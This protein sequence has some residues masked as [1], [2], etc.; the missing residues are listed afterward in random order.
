MSKI[1]TG[2]AATRNVPMTFARGRNGDIYGVN[3]YERGIRWDNITGTAEQLG[4]SAPANKPTLAVGS[5]SSKFYLS[6]IDVV[7]GGY[8]YTTE[9]RVRISGGVGVS[10]TGAS[11]TDV[12]TCNNHGFTDGDPVQFTALTGGAGLT[13]GRTYYAIATS[14]NTFQV[15]LTPGGVAVN[16]SSDIS[17]GTVSVSPGLGG[18]TGTQAKA[19]AKLIDGRIHRIVIQE[20]GT[21][22]DH[23]PLISVGKPDQTNSDGTGCVLTVEVSGRV[24][25]IQIDDLGSGYTDPVVCTLDPPPTGGELAVCRM[26]PSNGECG[27]VYPVNRGEGYTAPPDVTLSGGAEA[28][29]VMDYEVIAV[30]VTNGGSGYRGHPRVVFSGGNG[31]GAVAEPVVGPDGSIASV[32]VIHGGSYRSPP[33]ASLIPDWGA[34]PKMAVLKP[35]VTSSLKG[36]YWAAIRY[37]DD[38]AESEGGPIPSSI[39]E[40]ADIELDIN[41]PS[42]SWSWSNTGMES[43]VNQIELWRTTADQGLVLYRVAVLAKNSTSYT[44][45]FSDAELINTERANYGAM[46]ITL[47]NGQ[48]NAR[49][50]TPPP[51]NKQVI[52]MFQDRAWYG[53]DVPGRKYDGSSDSEAAEPNALYFSEADEP[54]AVPEVNQLIIQ[55][56]V[57]GQDMITA[58]MPFGGGM[59]VYQERHCYRLSYVAQP[60]I[61]ANITLI[62]QRG[63]LNQRCWDVYDNVAYVVDSAGM[64]MLDGASAVPISDA[65]DNYWTDDIIHFASSKWFFVRVDPTTRVVRFFHSVS[66]GY[67]DRALCFH[68]ITK[69]WWVE[70]YAQTFAGAECLTTGGRQRVIAGGQSGS[71]YLFDSGSQDINSAGSSAAIA[72]Q[73]RTGNMPMSLTENSR[74]VRVLYKPTTADCTLSLALHYNG[75]STARPAAVRTDR[76]VGFTT[77]GGAS[78]TLNLKKTRSALGDAT[79]YA[80]CHYAG[81]VDDKSSG[82]DRHIAIDLSLSRPTSESAVLYGAAVEGAGQ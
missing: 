56:N 5:G 36:K 21:G 48:L 72:C 53:V 71:M 33:T 42:L 81:R 29:C 7:D 79:G 12:I 58:L 78:A 37:I 43:R 82:G 24:Q 80:I 3:G 17:A 67:P 49:R 46:P 10:C 62:G 39:T 50:F 54:E 13:V 60:L 35:V 34:D 52:A 15:A 51:Q 25:E 75:S 57:K 68:P 65:I 66:A 9:P 18:R 27:I 30:N 19:K 31:G 20:Y 45:T 59:V 32:R 63:C 28:T 64:Y 40:L 26:W 4:I 11:A 23:A 2:S 1:F 8:G 77:D 61:D 76:G 74:A 55:E 44:D 41:S 38:T 16:F 22:Y 69:A 6:G 47:P 14:T 70:V 73:F